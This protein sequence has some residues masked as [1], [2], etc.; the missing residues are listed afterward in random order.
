MENQLNY[1]RYGT[2]E[3]VIIL[4]GLLGMLDN[5]HS[6]AKM[7]SEKYEVILI[8]QRNHGKSFHSNLFS[9]KHLADDI[10]KFLDHHHLDKVNLIGHSMGGKSVLQ[11]IN[12]YPQRVNKCI[13]VDIAPREYGGGHDQIFKALLSL[14]LNVAT[15]RK[16]IFGRLMDELKNE[17]VVYFLLKNLKRT[18]DNKFIWK[19]NIKDL[20]ENYNNIRS[21]VIF[22]TPY[23]KE[24]MFIRGDKSNY[25]SNEDALDLEKQ[26]SGLTFRS[27]SNA[28]HWVHADQPKE[29]L[30]ILL[31][32]LETKI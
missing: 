29:L 7:L 15:S 27:I 32:F 2:G 21:E 3:P 4:H 13:V 8:D 1:K 18:S 25:I 12:D 5:W 23:K 10:L 11:F 31:E 17:T 9:Y 22:T 20:W 16:E 30:S 19:A 26:F 24:I 6:F 28:G 14:D